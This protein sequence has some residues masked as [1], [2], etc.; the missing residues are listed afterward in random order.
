MVLSVINRI[1]MAPS[2]TLVERL[3]SCGVELCEIM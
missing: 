3:E 2:N 1:A